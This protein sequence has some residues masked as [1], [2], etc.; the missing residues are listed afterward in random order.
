M[1]SSSG[2]LKAYYP[3]YRYVTETIEML[4]QKN[5]G[6]LVARLFYQVA[7]LGRIHPAKMPVSSG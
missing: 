4:P 2:A 5:D 1:P 7:A 6:N 3:G